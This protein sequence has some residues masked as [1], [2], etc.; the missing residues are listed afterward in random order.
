MLDAGVVYAQSDRC[1]RSS[2]GL[3]M[4]LHD[5]PAAA[6]ECRIKTVARPAARYFF[7]L[8]SSMRMSAR[9]M[10]S[11]STNSPWIT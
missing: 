9:P 8:V 6:A 10:A 4:R 3:S 11:G 2:R 1:L 7:L 5:R